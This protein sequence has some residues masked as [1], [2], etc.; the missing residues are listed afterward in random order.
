MLW[1]I[2]NIIMI[3]IKHLEMSQIFGLD[4]PSEVDIPLNK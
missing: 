4:N 3:I 2:E 1:Y